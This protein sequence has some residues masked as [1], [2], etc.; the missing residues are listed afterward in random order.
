M[1]KLAAS[2]L[3]FCL[4]FVISGRCVAAPDQYLG[5]TSV[6]GGAIPADPNVLIIL[7]NSGSMREVIDSG[8]PYNPATTYNTTSACAGQAC[9]TNAVYRCTAF[10]NQCTNWTLVVANVSSVT[11]SCGTSN[12]RDSLRTTGQWRGNRLLTANG[13]CGNRGIA[14]YALGNWINWRQTTGSPRRKI[15]VAMDVVTNLISSTSDMRFGVMIFNIEQGGRLLSYNGYTASVKDMDARFSS[16][17]T[18]RQ[19]LVNAVNS[20]DAETW[21]PLGETL[22]EAMRYYKGQSSQFNSGVTYTSPIQAACQKNYVV[23]VTDGMSTQDRDPVLRTICNNGDCDGDGFE[24]ANDSA[25]TYT[26]EGSDYLD[27]VARYMN[28]NDMSSAYRGTQNVVTYTV[29]FGLG[30]SNA[31]A[32]KLL[33]EAAA[34]GGGQAFLADNQ[35][36]L[37]DTL[38]Q[39]LTDIFLMNSSFV[40]PVVPVNPANRSASGKRIYQS[41]FKPESS[42]PWHGNLKKFGVDNGVIVDKNGVA[43][44]DVDGSFKETAVSYWNDVQDGG[45]VN[46]GGV[47]AVLMSRAVASRDIYTWLSGTDLTSAGNAFATSNNNITATTLG[48][49]TSSEKD[50][51]VNYVRGADAYDDNGNGNTVEKRSWI[52]GDILHSRPLVVKLCQLRLQRHQ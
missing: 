4:M 5:D 17:L 51:L 9:Q 2:L 39:I 28:T 10:G 20:V 52:L 22:Y 44:T 19:A 6:Y 12:P 31:G 47:G 30:G 33:Q 38:G 8:V 11:T 35:A 14:T 50:K 26:W 29:G 3:V 42:G 25:K 34:N 21:T 48:V 45:E 23:L 40:A 16:S 1:K 49:A 13:A 46:M 43:A 37:A 18:N 15:D 24:P 36:M 32:V 27:D 41:L 7:D